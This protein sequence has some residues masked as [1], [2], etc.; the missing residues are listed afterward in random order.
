MA[1]RPKGRFI[2][3]IVLLDKD[4]GMS[5]NFALQ[6]VKRFFN[7][8]KA[9]HTGALD[10][11]ATGMLPICLGEA[12]KFSQHLL[13]SDKRYLVTAKLG[14]R[15]DTS[16][17][18]G[19]VV[20]TRPVN[21][22]QALLDEKLAFFRGTT[23]QIPSMYS[24]LKYQGQPLYKYA[25]EGIEVPRESRPITVFELNFIKLEGDELTLD[26]HCSKGTY[27][28]TIIDDLGEML[29]CGAHVVMLRRTQVA[30]YPYEK[31]VT[32]AQ[33]E[34][35]L[36]QAHRQDVAPQ[37]LMDPLL[38]PMDTAVAKFAEINLPEAML[39]YVMQGQAIQAAG[40]KPDELV[41]IT[42]GDERRFVGMGIMNDDGL[43]A[44]KRLIVI[45]D[46][47]AAE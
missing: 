30:E 26:I 43:L 18:D 20:Q 27:I 45:H 42:I 31:M 10:P 12:T 47:D 7:A 25:R 34:A 40:L 36:E 3:G 4:T 37:T 5:S 6:R 44:P 33:L 21:V 11:L 39:Y 41:R 16:D 8:N 2:D 46:N 24:A 14:Q 38:L 32:L 1:R 28:R 35:L 19:E 13:D 23:Q 15:T 22:T 29:G 17:S 9:G